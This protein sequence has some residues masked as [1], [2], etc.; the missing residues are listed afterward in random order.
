[1]KAIKADYVAKEVIITLWFGS[2]TLVSGW[3]V[4]EFST[5]TAFFITS[6]LLAL[7]IYHCIALSSSVTNNGVTVCCTN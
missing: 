6:G 5:N 1:M 2:M 7:A 3:I 4:D